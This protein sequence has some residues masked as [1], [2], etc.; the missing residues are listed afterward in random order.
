MSQDTLFTP[1]PQPPIILDH[2]PHLGLDELRHQIV[3]DLIFNRGPYSWGFA[4]DMS[5]S[6]LTMVGGG[7]TGVLDFLGDADFPPFLFVFGCL[8]FFLLSAVVS[9]G[10]EEAILGFSSYSLEQ[11]DALWDRLTIL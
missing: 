7:H 8:G 11:A 1:I 3:K 4:L 6:S 10:S 2:L 9:P 5:E